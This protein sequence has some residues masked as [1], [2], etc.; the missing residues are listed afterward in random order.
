MLTK[1]PGFFMSL[2]TLGIARAMWISQ[3]NATI[4]QGGAGFVFAWFL[5]P[6]AN[7]GVAKRLNGVLASTGS[8]YRISPMACFWLT[9]WPFIGA[10]RRHKNAVERINDVTRA[11]NVAG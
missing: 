10:R 2:V 9:G 11:R 5:L 8:G 7:Y 4:G 1:P 3:T 6:W